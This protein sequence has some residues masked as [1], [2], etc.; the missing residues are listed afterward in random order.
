M[1][2]LTME[3]GF[4]AGVNSMMQSHDLINHMTESI[5]CHDRVNQGECITDVIQSGNLNYDTT[6][7]KQLF[8]LS[9]NILGTQLNQ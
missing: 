4:T 5:T 9:H 8:Q 7:S 3:S 6:L 2:P 1:V